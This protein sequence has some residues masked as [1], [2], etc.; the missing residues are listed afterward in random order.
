MSSS[1]GKEVWFQLCRAY[2]ED[3]TSSFATLAL[4]DWF[5]SIGPNTAATDVS[6]IPLDSSLIEKVD[7]CGMSASVLRNDEHSLWYEYNT[8]RNEAR[9][10]VH[11]EGSLRRKR[12]VIALTEKLSAEFDRRDDRRA[13]VN[14]AYKSCR[15]E[16]KIGF[17]MLIHRMT[18]VTEQQTA[19]SRALQWSVEVVIF[20]ETD[21]TSSNNLLTLICAF[22]QLDSTT[23]DLLFFTIRPTL[24]DMYL[25]R[26]STYISWLA[27][28]VRRPE[29]VSSSGIKESDHIRTDMNGKGEDAITHLCNGL[30]HRLSYVFLLLFN[31]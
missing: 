17:K 11:K 9:S 8:L 15:L 26:L 14:A 5:D 12:K 18:H 25:H 1:S 23:E 2:F 13:A 7:Q 31:M 24:S 10:N 29:Q 19:C 27:D 22:C 16:D 3:S 30:P 6:I 4:F 20:S 21:E 28:D